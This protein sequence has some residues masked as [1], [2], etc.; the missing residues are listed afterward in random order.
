MEL[1]NPELRALLKQTKDDW[2]DPEINRQLL[3]PYGLAP[4]D[5][6]LYGIDIVTGELIL[7]I[8]QEKRRK[9]TFA[10]NVVINFMMSERETKPRTVID[11]LE[12][13]MTP[14]RYRDQMISNVA[15]RWLIDEGHQAKGQCA[16]CSADKC[17]QLFFT[18]E[19]LRY[20][21]R[22][23]VQLMALE[24]AMDNMMS[25]PLYIFGASGHQGSTRDLT[26]SIR[27]GR[28]NKDSWQ[29]DYVKEYS[30][31]STTPLGKVEKMSRWEFLTREFGA[32]IF[33]TD[34]V[35][36]YS[37]QNEI[38]DH[39]KQ[40]RAVAAIS[41]IVA[42][43]HIAALVLSQVS[44]TSVR[45]ARS[46]HGR[47]GAMGGSKLAQEA[48]VALSTHYEPDTGGQMAISIE[49]SRKSGTFHV[50]QRIE[51]RSGAFYGPAELRWK[52]KDL[53]QQL[54]ED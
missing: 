13:G 23:P 8:G 46:G 12:S 22:T 38:N 34:H 3:V 50:I 7:I 6:Y 29:H 18:P 25:W 17:R 5:Q 9:T 32:K 33:V 28:V 42:T 40:T 4:L 53:R 37:F 27:G 49:E 43:Q 31:T 24:F 36:Q 51:D 26:T 47:I 1:Y 21:S 45:D 19:F 14:T 39:E 15:S 35:Q 16:Q 52:R 10:I 2:G 11:T 44:L 54:D 41:D 30:T 20:H 48:N